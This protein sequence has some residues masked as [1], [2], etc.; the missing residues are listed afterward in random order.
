MALKEYSTLTKPLE[1]EP[2]HRIQL[3]VISRMPSLLESGESY[4]L[5]MDAVSRF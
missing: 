2:Y 4:L 3:I 5:V 1:L